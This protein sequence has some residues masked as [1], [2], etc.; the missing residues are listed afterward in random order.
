[1][2]VFCGFEQALKQRSARTVFHGKID[3]LL[4]SDFE[5]RLAKILS[6]N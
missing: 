1:L 4:I 5:G 6:S 3:L 2:S